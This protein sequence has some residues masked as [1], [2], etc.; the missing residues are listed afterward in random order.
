[1]FHSVIKN[2]KRIKTKDEIYIQLG[3]S[4]FNIFKFGINT[5]IDRI[6]Y[7]KIKNKKIE[8]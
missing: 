3:N 4:L 6:E 2:D 5:K 1:M 7:L 8:K